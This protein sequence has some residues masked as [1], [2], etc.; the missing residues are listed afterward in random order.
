MYRWLP[1]E[2]PV[3]AQHAFALGI[4]ALSLL[5]RW[6]LNDVLGERLPVLLTVGALV[7]LVLIVRPGPF[8]AGAAMGW[9]G[10]VY[11]FVPQQMSFNL[12]GPLEA[13]TVAYFMAVLAVGAAAG[14][15]LSGWRAEKERE[16]DE[17]YRAVAEQSPDGILVNSAGR[18]VFANAAAARL[19]GR[20]S[21]DDLIGGSPFEIVEPTQHGLVGERV[22]EVL[23]GGALLP[24]VEYRCRRL[25][26]THIDVEVTSGPFTWRGERA[27]L[28][29]MRDITERKRV[30][31]ELRYRAEQFETLLNQAPLGVYVVDAELRVA[32]VNPVAMSAF[33][34]RTLG[35]VIG[36]DFGELLRMAWP[37]PLGDTAIQMFRRTL[38]TG[39]SQHVPEFKEVRAGRNVTKYY[40]W[41]IDRITLPDGRYGVV[42]YFI[43]ITARKTIENALRKSEARLQVA[44]VAAQL[45]LHDFNVAANTVHWDARTRELWGVDADEPITYELWRDNVH[46]DDREEAEAAVSRALDPAGAGHYFAQYRVPNRRDGVTRWIEATGRT[47]FVRGQPVR[48]VGTT[49]DITAQKHTESILREEDRRKD[50]FIATLA[51]E[52]RNPLAAIRMGLRVIDTAEGDSAQ[53]KRMH[54]II[55]RQ[56]AQLVRLIDDLLDVSRIT[57]GKIE[58]R[59][60]PVSLG[61]V[62]EHAV[63]S[64]REMAEIKGLRLVVTLP[65]Q[66]VLIDADAL[67]FAQVLSNL[68]NNACKFTDRGGMICASAGREGGE[69]VVHV[70]DTGIGIPPE[71]LPRIFEMFA[72]VQGPQGPVSG[73]GIGLSLA[74]SIVELHGGSIEA[75]SNGHGMGSELVVRVPAVPDKACNVMFP[76]SGGQAPAQQSTAPGRVLA[77]DDNADALEAVAV[78]LRRAGHVVELAENGEDAIEKARAQR[79]EVVLLDIGLPG[80]DGYEVARRIRREPWGEASFL[81]AI[82]G[83]GREMDKRRAEEAGFDAHLTKPADPDE[84]ERLI[85]ARGAQRTGS[86]ASTYPL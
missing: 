71:Q 79:P 45:G 59:R 51:H 63:D 36:R 27:V 46:P 35:D 31:E 2:W 52:L 33:T 8:V 80:I 18:F 85:A 12:E 77:V 22:R 65:D 47:T 55:D 3:P 84:L 74:K 53:R 38:E 11:L 24:R 48:L 78:I 9:V 20:A 1:Y 15:R 76:R 54:A 30:Q 6:M 34:D 13:I 7:P 67:R 64:V 17:R 58:L 23:E 83:W 50:E 19:L 60:E 72:Q 40:D 32:Q 16:S 86:P 75:H 28:V 81:V 37:G 61:H 68:L 66:D 21:P 49:R 25:D 39:E 41:R 73:L 14:T 44:Q 29:S 42:C 43:D 10:S 4:V 62:L 56:S 5:V 26:G 69:A 70:R 82:T 57:R